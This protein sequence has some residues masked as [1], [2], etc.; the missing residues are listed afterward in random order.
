M[1]TLYSLVRVAAM[2]LAFLFF[3]MLLMPAH[4]LFPLVGVLTLIA[5]LVMLMRDWIAGLTLIVLGVGM[6]LI[7]VKIH[8]RQ[9]REQTD[10]AEENAERIGRM[11]SVH[12]PTDD[13]S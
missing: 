11:M 4:A 8:A 13:E 2:P 10:Q 12:L 5:G 3:G 7:G 6:I 1:I 9:Q